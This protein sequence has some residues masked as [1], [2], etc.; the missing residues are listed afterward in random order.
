[1]CYS[2]ARGKIILKGNII[3]QN[4]TCSVAYMDE[5]R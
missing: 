2:I 3:Y 5:K 4:L 1:M